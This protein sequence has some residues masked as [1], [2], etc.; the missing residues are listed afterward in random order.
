MLTLLKVSP[1]TVKAEIIL[2]LQN[3]PE[4]VKYLEQNSL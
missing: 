2:Q 3:E 1:N 4:E